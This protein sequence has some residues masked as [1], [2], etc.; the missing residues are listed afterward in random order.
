MSSSLRSSASSTK[1]ILP[2]PAWARQASANCSTS[3][4]R[5]AGPFACSHE[6]AL[7]DAASEINVERD[8]KASLPGLQ[9][10]RAEKV[11]SIAT[12]KRDRSS[13]IGGDGEERAKRFDEVSTAAES[14]RFQ[15]EQTQRRRQ[16]LLALK[17]EVDDTR[18]TKA[19]GRLRQLQQ[20][21]P[22]AGLGADQWKAF[23]LEFAGDVDDILAAAIKA[24]DTRIK[25][26]SEPGHRRSCDRRRCACVPDIASSRRVN[27]Y[28][29]HA[30]PPEQGG[31]SP[32]YADRYRYG[33][34]EGLRSPVRKDLP[35]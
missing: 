12:D 19:P 6:E 32:S 15:V 8:R 11:A 4:L 7:A 33:E 35:R 22:E 23:L 1:P 25:A 10:Q 28:R 14:V 17:D 34:R 20:A 13:L 24:A 2:K 16:A 29:Q 9:K 5:E 31:V 30:E 18:K 26:L 3:V 21:H 27:T